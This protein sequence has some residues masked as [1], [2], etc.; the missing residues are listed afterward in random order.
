MDQVN[1][2]L[3]LLTG[4]PAGEM[5]TAVVGEAGG[6]LLRWSATQVDHQPRGRTTVG[7]TARVRWGDGTETGET[8]GACSGPL[9]EGVVRL[10]DG[11]TE[12]GVW[13]FPYDPELPA[14]PTAFDAA[15]VRRLLEDAGLRCDGDV[16]LRLRSY[17]PRRRAVVEATTRDRRQVFVK[18]VRPSRARELHERHRLA[19]SAAVPQSLG[20]TG[21]GLVL[22]AGLPGRTLRQ[23]LLTEEAVALDAASVVSALDGLPPELADGPRRRTWGQK[24]GH[25]AEVIAA[26]APEFS[27]RATEIARAVDHDRPQGPDVPVHGDLY[28][29]QLLVR[30]GR[31]TGLLDIDGAGRGERLDDAGCL[32]GHLAV[33]GQLHPGKAASILAAGAVLEDRFTADLDRADLARRAAAVVLSLATGP[34]RVQEPE[35]RRR[36]GERLALAERL[37]DEISFTRGAALPSSSD[38]IVDLVSTVKE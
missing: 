18:V 38:G 23:V 30:H 36:T 37:L 17:R 29:N 26:A 16:R 22:L 2:E 13:R 10:S 32:L 34:H 27:A 7:Y 24:A 3:S 31:V 15:G 1:T 8:F 14:L 5:L 11:V 6:T 20:W 9:P 12:I 28:E 19:A 4:E 25:Y 35:W 21:D 33:L